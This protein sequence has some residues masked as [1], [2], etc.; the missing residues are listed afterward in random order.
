MNFTCWWKTGAYLIAYLFL[1][2][3]AYDIQR[4][5]EPARARLILGQGY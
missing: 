1:T 2:P 4:M 3:E 5:L